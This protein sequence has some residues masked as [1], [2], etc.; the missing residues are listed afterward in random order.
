M[1]NE[2]RVQP[3][4]IEHESIQHSKAREQAGVL[5]HKARQHRMA[6]ANKHIDMATKFVNG[7][8]MFH[9]PCSSWDQEFVHGCGY[10]HLSSSTAGTRKK[11][12][13]NGRLSSVSGNFDKEL[14]RKHELQQFPSFMRNIVSWSTR[15]I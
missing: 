9:Q 12:C 6:N 3:G 10:I 15:V 4:V 14:M 2:R 8:Y 7:K 11:C 13:S 5:E 1:S